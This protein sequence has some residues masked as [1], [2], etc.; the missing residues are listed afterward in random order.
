MFE[1]KHRGV[2]LKPIWMNKNSHSIF[3][4]QTNRGR[5]QDKLIDKLIMKAPLNTTVYL[6]NSLPACQAYISVR[7]CRTG[8]R[9]KKWIA[10]SPLFLLTCLSLVYFIFCSPFFFFYWSLSLL[11]FSPVMVSICISK[12]GNIIKSHCGG[13]AAEFW[14]VWHHLLKQSH[15]PPA[16]DFQAR[17]L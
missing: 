1:Q 10:K 17:E 4:W 8:P 16:G 6:P 13:P 3:L 15:M 9:T 2:L 14:K 11:F 12:Q 5:N 7:H